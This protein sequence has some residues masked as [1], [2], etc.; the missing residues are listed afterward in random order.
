MPAYKFTWDHFD[1]QTVTALA[2]AEGYDR[3]HHHE[4]SARDYLAGQV[5]RPTGAFVSEHRDVLVRHW[6]PDYAG[7]K[8]IV[9]RLLDAGVGPLG[10]PRS[11]SG[12]LEYIS[13]TR[14]SKTFRATLRAA[15][16]QFGDRA[17]I[18]A[19]DVMDDSFVPRFAVL[20]IAKQVPDQR[21]PF[22]HQVAAWERMSANLAKAEST[23]VF[24][25][26][27][28]MPTG[29]GKTFTAVQWLAR[30]VLSRGMQVL[31]L[32]HRSELLRHAASE[33]QTSAAMVD[34]KIG[35]LRVR[36]VSGEHCSASQIDPADHVV[37]ASISSLRYSQDIRDEL[38]NNPRTFVVIDEAHHAPAKSYRDVIQVLRKQQAW[39]LLGLTATP[40]RTVESERSTLSGLFGGNIIHQVTLRELIEGGILA[41]P[42]LVRVETNADVEAGITEDDRAHAY[43]FQDLSERWL[44]RIADMADRN[45]VI[46][47]H[48]LDHRERYGCTI[49]FAVNVVHAALLAAQ[50]REHG[51]RADYVASYRPD[52]TEGDPSERIE[53]LR[54]G[55]LEVL[56]NVQLLTEGVDVPNAKTIFLT[57]PTGSEILFRQ[58]VGRALRGPD[59]GGTTEAYLVSFEDCWATYSN[60]ERPFDLLMPELVAIAEPKPA[61]AAKVVEAALEWLPWDVIRSAAARLYATPI[62]QRADVFDIISHGWYLLEREE[63]DEDPI[64]TS[65]PVYEH[66]VPCVEAL[67]DDL[68]R[69]SIRGRI[70]LETQYIEYFGDCDDP[71]LPERHFEALVGHWLDGGDRPKH[72][73]LADR[74][75]CD[76]LLVAQR[77]R[78]QDL[79]ERARTTL[80]TDSYTSLAKTIYPT[81]R[82]YSSAIEDALHELRFPQDSTR[83]VRGVPLFEP[84]SDIQMRP[85]QHDLDVLMKETLERGRELLGLG[86][87]VELGGGIQIEWTHRLIKGWY[88]MAYYETE[89]PHGEG[90][91]R[92]NRLLN[93]ADVSAETLRYLLWHEY[94]HLF[95]KVGHTKLFRQHE[96]MWPTWTEGDR[97]MGTINER[98]G[99]QYW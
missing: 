66:Q 85:G 80:V 7:L 53:A 14:R 35:K 56:V 62:D 96:R 54:S 47:R 3:D 19:D 89:T 72:N 11:K 75:I 32:A 9:D 61:A 70:N 44:Q 24:Q 64:C 63:P 31:W 23:K 37:I 58:M 4:L 99:V 97:E 73:A 38:L 65:I 84:P 41:R 94:L 1:D 39:R 79:G 34:P 93:S 74:S 25:G 29:A 15:M 78:D 27:L 87:E 18:D 77:I 50:L 5:K 82:D 90:R 12:Y 40:T 42:T 81:L 33:F 86:A 49:M 48:Y 57:R 6:L 17:S 88:A 46:V 59:A 28:V 43:R 76:P 69:R 98:F 21:K 30:E 36:V 52:N 55:D 51:V 16:I 20:D 83:R 71:T 2:K 92:V 26:M 13:K 67:L 45:K 91:I 95:L 8:H 68:Y 60:W 22:R 10:S